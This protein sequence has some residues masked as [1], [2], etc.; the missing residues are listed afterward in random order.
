MISTFLL[1]CSGG[2]Q[3]ANPS[4]RPDF[5]SIPV[6]EPVEIILISDFNNGEFFGRVSD[7]V[8]S[9][10]GSILAA[11]PGA[12]KI[13]IFDRSGNYQ[14]FVGGDGEGPGEF[15]Q[16][17]MI[18]MLPGDILAVNDW[19]LARITLFERNNGKWEAVRFFD[20]PAGSREYGEGLFFAFNNIYSTDDG[21][22]VRFSTS[23]TPVDTATHTYGYYL[24]YD[25]NLSLI[26]ETEYL[27]H[28]V[29]RSNVTRSGSGVMV[30]GYPEPHLMRY[31]IL[32]GGLKVSTHSS[33]RNVD[34]QQITGDVIHSFE[35][36]SNHIPITESEKQELAEENVPEQMRAGGQLDATRRLIPDYKG[37]SR[38][39]LVDNQDQIW[40]LTNQ[41]EE[42]DP[43]WLVYNMD[44][45]L[46][47]AVHHP[48]GT[49]SAIHGNR[50]IV[51][52]S[53]ADDEPSVAVFEF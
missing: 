16:I 37:Y 20:R 5:D 13:Q 51:R 11:D 1:S 50:M 48:G 17:G 12:K 14:G 19:Q 44:G 22:L 52:Y 30:R 35:F 45:E 2:G 27:M 8:V 4:E 18:S 15:R 33:K 7:V 3:Q 29:M 49:V 42:G 6:A 38:A 25:H 23:F 40:I 26:D 21:Y 39:L 53:S 28:T 32:P 31:S 41:F 9:S 36:T 10:D 43:E 47:K 24:R 46:L 34:V